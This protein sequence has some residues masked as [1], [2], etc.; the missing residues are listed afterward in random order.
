MAVPY[1]IKSPLNTK[2]T[3]VLISIVIISG[4]AMLL[5]TQYWMNRYHEE[6]T[7]KLNASIAM[8][9]NDEYQLLSGGKNVVNLAAIKQLS[10]QDRKSVV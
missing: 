2:L 5:S 4:L 9:I 1:W 8:Y 7:Q 10:Q 3:I 6:S